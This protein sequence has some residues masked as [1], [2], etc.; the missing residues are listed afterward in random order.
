[1]AMPKFII[2][3]TASLAKALTLTKN[4]EQMNWPSIR[5][6]QIMAATGKFDDHSSSPKAFRD[7]LSTT[8]NY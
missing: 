1:M 7:R 6:S 5:I 2:G 3:I 4:D 8:S